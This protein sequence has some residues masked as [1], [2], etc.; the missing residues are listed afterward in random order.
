MKRFFVTLFSTLLLVGLGQSP[1]TAQNTVVVASPSPSDHNREGL[2]FNIGVGYGT[3]GCGPCTERDGGLSGG[4]SAGTTL[5][6][7]VLI[8]G[9]LTGWRKSSG[10][11]T[12]AA[13]LLTPLVRVYTS[14]TEGFFLTGGVGVGWIDF[15]LA[16]QLNRSPT[17]SRAWQWAHG[18]ENQLGYAGLAG[19]GY[20]IRVGNNGSLTPFL[21][22]F[23]INGDENLASINVVQFGV[24]ATIH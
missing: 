1:L 15:T 13:G 9:G 5:S 17:R 16:N 20:D 14:G 12:V 21:N 18:S 7:N 23:Y 19:L 2:W 8:G 3:S 24:G 22:G 10:A 4:L 6:D 11:V